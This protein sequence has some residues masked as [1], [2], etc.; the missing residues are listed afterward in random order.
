VERPAT[1]SGPSQ[2]VA[3]EQQLAVVAF[4]DKVWAHGQSMPPS[5]SE[6]YRNSTAFQLFR[7]EDVRK[8]DC[9]RLV[10]GLLTRNVVDVACP[11]GEV[12]VQGAPYSEAKGEEIEILFQVIL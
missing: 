3:F 1:E 10:E 5:P 2:S 8:S 11:D 12:L 7:T 4:P 9:N 6:R